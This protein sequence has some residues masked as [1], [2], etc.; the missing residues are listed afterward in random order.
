MS[1][2]FG[3]R[4]ARLA[5]WQCFIFRDYALWC[6]DMLKNFVCLPVIIQSS[7]PYRHEI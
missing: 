1:R 2:Y 6:K 5:R 3:W 4:Y 7:A